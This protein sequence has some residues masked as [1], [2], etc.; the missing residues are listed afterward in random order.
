MSSSFRVGAS[1]SLVSISK[2]DLEEPSEDI[3]PAEICPDVPLVVPFGLVFHHSFTGLVDSRRNILRSSLSE[4][5][6]Y[7][8]LLHSLDAFH[9]QCPHERDVEHTQRAR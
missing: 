7:F 8:E 6:F 5:D 9:V 2:A 1:R 3:V 4:I